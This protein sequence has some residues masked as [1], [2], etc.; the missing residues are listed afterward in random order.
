[1]HNPHIQTNQSCTHGGGGSPGSLKRQKKKQV[2]P[3]T[4]GNATPGHHLTVRGKNAPTQDGVTSTRTHMRTHI[5]ALSLTHTHTQ[6]LIWQNSFSLF[7]YWGE[8]QILLFIIIIIIIVNHLH[9][10]SGVCMEC[11][12]LC[13]SSVSLYTLLTGWHAESS[14]LIGWRVFSPLLLQDA[15]FTFFKL[16]L[17]ARQPPRPGVPACFCWWWWWCSHVVSLPPTRR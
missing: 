2:S 9:H 15:F 14:V 10:S 1:M 8:K 6:T 17:V 4:H 3:Q 13:V 5:H 11:V 7:F 12:C 16:S